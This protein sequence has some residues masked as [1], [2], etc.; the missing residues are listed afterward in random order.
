LTIFEELKNEKKLVG[1]SVF[2]IT[3]YSLIFWV[4]QL[5]H[6]QN[7]PI[8]LTVLYRTWDYTYFNMIFRLFKN[9][10]SEVLI[11]DPTGQNSFPY[12]IG[13]MLPYSI[14]TAI[15]GGWGFMLGDVFSNLLRLYAIWF[16]LKPISKSTN[17]RAGLSV[18]LFFL[19]SEDILGGFNNKWLMQGV[20]GTRIPRPMVTSSFLFFALG[21]LL[22][23]PEHFQSISKKSLRNT[24]LLSLPFALMLNSDTFGFVSIALLTAILLL[25]W[26]SIGR[27][28]IKAILVFC[29]IALLL[30]LPSLYFIGGFSP[31]VAAR[32][33][34]YP[35][36][37]LLATIEIPSKEQI[38]LLVISAF[39]T[40]VAYRVSTTDKKILECIGICTALF[41]CSFFA[42]VFV[43]SVR[44]FNIHEY[45]YAYRRDQFAGLL[46]AMIGIL[47]VR[48]IQEFLKAKTIFY[49]IV[50]M[51]LAYVPFDKQYDFSKE[52]SLKTSEPQGGYLGKSHEGWRQAAADLMKTIREKFADKDIVVGALDPQLMV[53][54]TM[55]SNIYLYLP[56][57]YQTTTNTE[58]LIDRYLSF[59]ILL[60]YSESEVAKAIMS[61]DVHI[62]YLTYDLFQF[63]RFNVYDQLANYSAEALNNLKFYRDSWSVV[64]PEKE[65]QKIFNRYNELKNIIKSNGG[66][67]T[68]FRNPD[69]IIL[70][71]DPS[72]D[73]KL[74]PGYRQLVQNTIF[75]VFERSD[76][77]Q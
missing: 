46:I 38:L 67:L 17:E 11:I 57:P 8:N 70:N 49:T 15:F 29:L 10:L 45:Q 76:L 56:A 7:E 1:F 27:V 69:L 73:D 32:L 36:F 72:T 30:C 33:G 51:A 59:C 37:D 65:G 14:F 28:D 66:K 5:V 23:I 19:S 2:L 35:V 21:A 13:S 12:P 42:S 50:S 34:Q 71:R 60:N 47:T 75:R 39:L 20:W 77:S 62:N 3:I 64:V 24:I 9:F 53:Y 26:I 52:T 48:K 63:N 54:L 6:N 16:F 31:E 44:G 18:I 25:V 61:R 68:R 74:P 55:H 41:G 22:R 58:E 43:S 40:S 4:Q